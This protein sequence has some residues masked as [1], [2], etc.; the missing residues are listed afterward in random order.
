MLLIKLGLC[1]CVS[2]EFVRCNNITVLY[3]AFAQHI[4]C[5]QQDN[6]VVVLDK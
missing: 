6:N 1:H 5:S 3:V 2:D 4:M